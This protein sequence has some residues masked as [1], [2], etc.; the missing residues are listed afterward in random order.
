VVAKPGRAVVRPDRARRHRPRRLHLRPRSAPKTHAVHPPVQ[1]GSQ[2][3][4]VALPRPDTSHHSRFTRY[5][6]LVTRI[7]DLTLTMAPANQPA[8][9]YTRPIVLHP[10]TVRIT[11]WLNA[12]AICIM[13]GS[14]WRIYNCE[15][16]FGFEFPV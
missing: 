5:S 10:L 15:P 3:Y 16:L 8:A 4:K 6:P 9:Q 1:Q 14:G 11:H 2:N 12:L 7:G 13:I